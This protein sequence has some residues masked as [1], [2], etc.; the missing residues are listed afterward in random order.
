VSSEFSLGDTS[1]VAADSAEE[2]KPSLNNTQVP[3]RI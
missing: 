3:S 1:Q 2:S